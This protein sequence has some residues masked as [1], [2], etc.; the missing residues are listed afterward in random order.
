MKKRILALGCT[1]ALLAFSSDAFAAT[2]TATATIGTAI[3][4]T[5]DAGG[6]NAGN[7]AFGHIIPGTGGTVTIAPDGTVGQTG[8]IT[9]TTQLTKSAAQFAVSGDVGK[10]YNVTLPADNTVTISNGTT[11][12]RVDGFTKSLAGLGTLD[13]SGAQTFK[14]GGTLTVGN[15]QDTGFYTGTF[16]VTA[17]YQ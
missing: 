13:A 6:T 5:Q 12:M 16:T 7:L 10:T 14:V 1:A 11:T 15:A 4:I 9:L 8:A 3:S 2:G 17:A